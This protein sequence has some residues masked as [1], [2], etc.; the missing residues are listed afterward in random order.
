MRHGKW[1]CLVGLSSVVVQTAL[2]GECNHDCADADQDEKGCCPVPGPTPMVPSTPA[3][4]KPVPRQVT[5]G[6]VAPKPALAAGMGGATCEAG[7]AVTADT[8][9]HCCWAGQVWS[10]TRTLCVGVPT[11]CPPGFAVIG[12]RCQ[13]PRGATVSRAPASVVASPTLGAMRYIPA[14]SFTMGSP[15]TEPL[16]EADEVQHVVTLTRGFYL[17]EHEVTQAQWVRTMGSNPSDSSCGPGCPVDLVSWDDAV[18]FAALLSDRDGRHYRLPTEAEW[19]YAARGPSE[20][21]YAG[22]DD[23]DAVG[24]HAGNAQGAAHLPCLRQR[25]GFGL[26]DMSGNV[27]EWTSDGY[28]AYTPGP[29]TDPVGGGAM[30]VSRGGSWD[31][32]QRY[33]RVAYRDYDAT[34]VSRKDLGFRL[35]MAPP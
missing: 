26:C 31:F 8:A 22:S 12:E 25:N 34:Y 2:S 32:P 5:D 16:R 10:N 20:G 23:A 6:P 4:S 30:R 29:A 14:G 3:V 27:F 1:L 21:P 11:S 15:A 9:G 19:E 28:A 18:E 35:A 7:M 17:M 24:W 33:Q 13:G